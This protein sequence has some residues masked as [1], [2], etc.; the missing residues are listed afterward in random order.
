M[1]ELGGKLWATSEGEERGATFILTLP[2][3]SAEARQDAA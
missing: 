2:S 1:T 3:V